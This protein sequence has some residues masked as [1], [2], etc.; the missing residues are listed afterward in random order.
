MSK[1]YE[2]NKLHATPAYAFIIHQCSTGT[3]KDWYECTLQ[4]D[5][6]TERSMAFET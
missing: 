3:M 5:T 4:L 1:H 2:D 6:K